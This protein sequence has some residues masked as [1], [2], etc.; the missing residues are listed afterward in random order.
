MNK[1]LLAL[2]LATTLSCGTW[3]ASTAMARP[4]SS[5]FGPVPEQLVKPDGSIDRGQLPDYVSV[6]DGAGQ[7]TGYVR[8]SFLFPTQPS[9]PRNPTEASRSRDKVNPW[10]VTELYDAAGTVIGRLIVGYGVVLNGQTGPDI[11]SA[12]PANP[13]VITE[14]GQP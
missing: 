4:T 3:Y 11:G 2:G 13:A 7:L 10:E 12:R 5:S 14:A 1:K 6:V 8:S 9:G